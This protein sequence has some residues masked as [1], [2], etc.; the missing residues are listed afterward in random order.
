MFSIYTH[1][2]DDHIKEFSNSCLWVS[3]KTGLFLS[4]RLFKV[5][6]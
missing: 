1:I 5:C 3:P 2:Y 4:E 6:K